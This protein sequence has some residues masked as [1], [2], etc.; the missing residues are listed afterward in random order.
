MLFGY[1]SLFAQHKS[2]FSSS[3][4]TYA[5]LSVTQKA[6]CDLIAANPNVTDVKLVNMEILSLVQEDGKLLLELPFLPCANLVFNAT[7]VSYTNDD[8]YEWYG[9]VK[10]TNPIDSN[11]GDGF[12]TMVNYA[13]SGGVL[14]SLVLTEHEYGIYDLGE[15]VKAFAVMDV[16]RMNGYSCGVTTITGTGP[17]D[18]N[19]PPVILDQECIRKQLKVLVLYTPAAKA[20]IS[21][22]WL[23]ATLSIFKT[24]VVY[25]NSNVGYN[26]VLAGAVELPGFVEYINIDVETDNIA[27][28]PPAQALRNDVYKADIVVLMSKKDYNAGRNGNAREIGCYDLTTGVLEKANGYAVVGVRF[29]TSRL[30]FPHEL[31]HLLGGKHDDDDRTSPSFLE[32]TARGNKFEKWWGITPVLIGMYRT[33]V[34]NPPHWAM[35]LNEHR[36]TQIPYLSNPDVDY[37]NRATGTTGRNNSLRVKN[38]FPIIAGFYPDYTTFTNDVTLNYTI[39]PINP[40]FQ[41]ICKYEKATLYASAY[42]GRPAYTHNWQTSN[43]GINWYNSGSGATHVIYSVSHPLFVRLISRDQN[44]LGV[45]VMKQVTLNFQ[46]N[47]NVIEVENASHKL[48]VK[49]NKYSLAPNPTNGIFELNYEAKETDEVSIKLTDI[50]GRVIGTLYQGALRKGFGNLSLGENLKLAPGLYFV[51]INGANTKQILRLVVQ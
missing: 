12:L 41:R 42:C 33:T 11:C 34:T 43:D 7:Q 14:G 35:G 46:C 21:N 29:S 26:V 40:N 49:A 28:N 27:G 48:D 22:M 13:D 1:Q 16:V 24:N 47:Q 4:A 10:S 36:R 39:A 38:H 37:N 3:S 23:D 19:N 15:G 17:M 18:P 51:Q 50:A 9:E 30:I 25:N 45:T 20:S 32:S 6:K 5:G 2:F 44:G 31:S 8:N